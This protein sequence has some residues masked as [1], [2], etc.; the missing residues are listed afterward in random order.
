MACDK[1]KC[2]EVKWQESQY[3]YILSASFA[4]VQAYGKSLALQCIDMRLQYILPS[5]H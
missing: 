2:S 5:G 3:I 1:V 4:K